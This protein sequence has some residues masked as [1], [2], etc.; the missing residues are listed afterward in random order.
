MASRPIFLPLSI[1]PW[2]R[3]YPVEFTWH[4]GLAV[5]Q[6]Q[7]SIA[8][9]HEAARRQYHV[10]RLLEISSKST[11]PEGVA[12]S[13]FNLKIELPDGTRV[14]LECAYQ[15][16]KRFTDGGPHTELYRVAPIDAK[17]D[18]RVKGTASRLLS[19]EY[20]GTS[21]PLEPQSLFYDWLYIT[22]MSQS[23]NAALLS[24]VREYDGY[25]DIEFNPEKSVSCQ[26]NSAAVLTGMSKASIDL[27]TA[28]VPS[29][30]RELSLVANGVTS[31][32]QARLF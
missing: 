17:R 21:W 11:E 5:S 2:V 6:K 25:T 7:K 9:L 31:E 29:R 14:P 3:R 19:F 4:A 27:K 28:S 20:F 13:A 12:A 18:Q 22:A 15:G 30:F 8:C 16:S 10:S 1:P 23:H 26:A 24:S 32:G